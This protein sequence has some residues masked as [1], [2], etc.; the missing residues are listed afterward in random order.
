MVSGLDMLCNVT[1]CCIMLHHAY[2]NSV[3]CEGAG[4]AAKCVLVGWESPP[5]IVKFTNLHAEVSQ[6]WAACLT[7]PHPVNVVWGLEYSVAG[8]LGYGM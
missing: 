6:L 2:V 3:L 1:S 7:W 4:V 5:P 8:L